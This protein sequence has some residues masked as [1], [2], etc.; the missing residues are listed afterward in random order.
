MSRDRSFGMPLPVVRAVLGVL[1][2]VQLVDGLYALI[3]PRAFYDDFPFGRGWVEALPAYSEHLVRDVGALFLATAV[4]LLAA[5]V[6]AER[7]LVAVALVSF[8]AFSVPH[9]VFHMFNLEPYGTGDAIG[10]VATL[11]L[12][13]V[14]PLV[15][16]VGMGRA[17]SSRARA[18]SA[19]AAGGSPGNGRITG[20]PDTTRNPLVR[21]A[22]RNSR[23]RS[24]DVMDPLRIY[25]HNPTVMA[26]YGA[27]ELASERSTRV[28]ERIKHL[29]TVRAAMVCGCEWCLDFGTYLSEDAGVGE[30]DLR[31]LLAPHW[32][33]HFDETE[34]LVLD[35]ATA[36]SRTPAD[37]PDELFDGLRSRFDEAQL[38]ELTSI[39]AL[40]NYRA[41]FNWAFGLEGQGYSE[42]SFCVPPDRTPERAAPAPR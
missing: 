7:R 34:C 26:G 21:G 31:A 10:N 14:L 5:A 3:A 27:F 16:L 13:I 29:A 4:I 30:D 42:G 40:E 2:A 32:G 39:I 12:T 8:L 15:I 19:G 20:V 11:L 38:V 9:F 18:R 25:A 1:G 28:P 33:D 6:I 24:G 36:M 23:K 22:F 37:V 41:R 17:G 35:Y